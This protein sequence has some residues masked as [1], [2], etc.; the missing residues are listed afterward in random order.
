M[1]LQPAPVCPPSCSP[2]SCALTQNTMQHQSCTRASDDTQAA[3]V[4]HGV[5]ASSRKLVTLER[6]NALS[7][8][9]NTGRDWRRQLRKKNVHALQHGITYERARGFRFGDRA[10]F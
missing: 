2:H 8:T 6:S 7:R 10:G 4:R 3:S 9:R 1:L 5:A